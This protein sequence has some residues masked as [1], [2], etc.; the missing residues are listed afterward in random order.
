MR[1]REDCIRVSEFGHDIAWA[2]GECL[3]I[4][5]I[6]MVADESAVEH[7]GYQRSG[8]NY[9]RLV[10]RKWSCAA[11]LGRQTD[12]M[13]SILDGEKAK[14]VV[15]LKTVCRLVQRGFNQRTAKPVCLR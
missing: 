10:R 7:A 12:T 8:R 11:C 3:T 9:D 4:N 13:S 15:R 14:D 6:E 1:S 5:K 2:D